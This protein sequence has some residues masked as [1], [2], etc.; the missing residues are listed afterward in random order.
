[1]PDFELV[2]TLG[3][4]ATASTT[5][6]KN[7]AGTLGRFSDALATSA[8]TLNG[9][10]VKD[11]IDWSTFSIEESLSAFQRRSVASFTMYSPGFR[12]LAGMEF[13]CSMPTG[14]LLFAGRLADASEVDEGKDELRYQISCV[15]WTAD[16]DRRSVVTTF[17]KTNSKPTGFSAAPY[18]G[19]YTFSVMV[20]W[21]MDTFARKDQYG[22]A[23]DPTTPTDLR[24]G[25]ANLLANAAG[26]AEIAFIQFNY[27]P[28]SDAIDQLAQLAGFNWYVD[29]SK[30]MHGWS[31]QDGTAAATLDESMTDFEDLDISVDASQ[32][33][34]RVIVKGGT[35]TTPRTQ[36]F[37]Q[38][39]VNKTFGLDHN[40]FLLEDITSI[41]VAGGAAISMSTDAALDDGTT[42]KSVYIN[43]DQRYLRFDDTYIITG[44]I[45]VVY[46]SRDPVRELAQDDAAITALSLLVG[47]SSGLREHIIEDETLLTADSAQK[48]A[49]AEITAYSRPRVQGSVTYQKP[50]I[51]P[52]M[53]LPVDYNAQR[54]GTDST[55]KDSSG[56]LTFNPLVQRVVFRP[57]GTDPDANTTRFGTWQITFGASELGLQQVLG[58]IMLENRKRNPSQVETLEHL[59]ALSEAFTITESVTQ[60]RNSNLAY[61]W[62]SSSNDPLWDF[63]QWS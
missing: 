40:F 29:Y 60:T 44:N 41:T 50:G 36:V 35:N 10:S 19:S 25:Y 11:F 1:M 20:R 9:Y 39:G 37:S 27:V 33:R 34:N 22:V 31:T 17:D 5:T 58:Q 13:R 18:N 56:W 48:R 43:P 23:M 14:T 52:G 59:L 2:G 30:D 49:R 26:G 42:G 45:T 38:V 53:V 4:Y 8:F 62:G 47:G 51:R 6:D 12:P 7:A 46:L 54:E 24:I 57:N 32:V 15:D 28:V 55:N 63:G 3:R 21:I 61:T 16:L